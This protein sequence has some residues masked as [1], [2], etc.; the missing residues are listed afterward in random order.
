[1]IPRK[2]ISW[3]GEI[4]NPDLETLA[5]KLIAVLSIA[6][7]SRRYNPIREDEISTAHGKWL[8]HWVKSA[9]EMTPFGINYICENEPAV[10][11]VKLNDNETKESKLYATAGIY[12]LYHHPNGSIITYEAGIVASFEDLIKVYYLKDRIERENP[13][14][15][16]IGVTIKQTKGNFESQ[17]E[18]RRELIPLKTNRPIIYSPANGENWPQIS[19]EELMHS[20]FPAWIDRVNENVLCTGK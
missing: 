7:H 12:A 11:T 10:I 9:F 8:Y 20:G 19:A 15:D 5:D 4:G 2:P 3:R 14:W 18:V 16:D 17:R 1:M 13:R 6:R